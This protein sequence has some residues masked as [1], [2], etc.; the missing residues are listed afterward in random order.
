MYAKNLM[1]IDGK[2]ATSVK[3]IVQIPGQPPMDMT[4]MLAGQQTPPAS[5]DARDS[6]EHVGTEDVTT[7]AG[8]FSCEHYK[9]KDGTW[10]AWLSSKVIPWGLVKSSSNNDTTMVLTK[11]ISG[12]T[13]HITGTPVQMN[14]GGMRGGQAPPH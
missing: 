1:V 2:T 10:E 12:A 7:S 6:A 14:M 11:V 3:M 13:D 4:S 8:T 9:A 5:I